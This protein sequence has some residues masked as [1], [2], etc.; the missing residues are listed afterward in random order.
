[1]FAPFILTN[2]VLELLNQLRL[3]FGL[4]MPGRHLQS[5]VQLVLRDRNSV[6]Q[7]ANKAIG[8]RLVFKKVSSSFHADGGVFKTVLIQRFRLLQSS[9]Y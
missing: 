5:I 8:F 9:N 7:V 3:L 1:L 2:R 4:D 6:L